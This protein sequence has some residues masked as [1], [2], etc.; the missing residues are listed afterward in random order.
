MQVVQKFQ[1][2]PSTRL[3]VGSLRASGL[4]IS[5]TAA[6][7]VVFVE[8]DWSPSIVQQAEDRCHRVGQTA[9]VLVQ[10][11][12]FEGTID[13]HLSQLLVE[14]QRTV[15]ATIEEPQKASWVFDFGKHSGEAISDVAAEDP[16]YLKWLVDQD[17]HTERRTKGIASTTA[18][19]D[20]GEND[21]EEER[22]GLTKALMELGFLNQQGQKTPNQNSSLESSH[23]DANETDGDVEEA[24]DY[25]MTFGKHR[26]KALREIPNSYLVWMSDARVARGN[27]GLTKA[28]RIHLANSSSR[29]PK[30]SAP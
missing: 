16:A 11:L 30:S 19:D 14:K 26:G 10:Y 5:L 27:P 13:E 20:E 9:S 29:V 15:A 3:F 25:I 24:G 18:S 17:I 7:H 22:D 2:D 4:G 8:M 12:F 23:G 28:L 21:C 1:T 6:S